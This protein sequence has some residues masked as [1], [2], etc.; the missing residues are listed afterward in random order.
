[1]DGTTERPVPM[2]TNGVPVPGDTANRIFLFTV[3]N[4][5]CLLKGK[6]YEVGLLHHDKG[7][8][9]DAKVLPGERKCKPRG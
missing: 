2:S 1:M 8:K 9:D 6:V 3:G 5:P 4:H 7:A